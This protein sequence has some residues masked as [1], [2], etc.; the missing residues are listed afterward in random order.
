MSLAEQTGSFLGRSPTL[1]R[2]LDELRR[3]WEE[4]AW[5]ESQ[6]APPE[7]FHYCRVGDFHGITTKRTLWLSDVLTLNDASEMLYAA[8]SDEDD[9][10]FRSDPSHWFR[11]E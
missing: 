4:A 9:W 7:L 3:A 10:R 1:S 11:G 6:H 5:L 2:A 8:Y